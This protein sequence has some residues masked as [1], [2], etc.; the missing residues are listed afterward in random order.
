MIS[1]SIVQGSSIGPASYVLNAS[2]LKAIT[3]G[4][5][6]FKYADDTYI[7]IPSRNADSRTMELD[8]I[9]VWSKANNL[10]LNRSKCTEIIFSDNKRKKM[11]EPPSLISG[12]TRVTSM[13]ILGVTFTNHLS[14]SDHVNQIVGKCAHTLYAMRILRAQGMCDAALNTVYQSVIVARIMHAA[15]AWWGFTTAADRCRI[16]AIFS[17]WSS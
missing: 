12:L 11:F 15:C 9:A 17:P 14:M 13:K 2:D 7:I 16:D 10:K 3:Q 6:T 8:N 1:A 5:E 4:N